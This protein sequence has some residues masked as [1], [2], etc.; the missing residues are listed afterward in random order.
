M[1][2]S[3]RVC[4]CVFSFPLLLAARVVSRV[5]GFLN[6]DHTSHLS[7]DERVFGHFCRVGRTKT[8]SKS[9]LLTLFSHPLPLS[10]VSCLIALS[11]I[12]CKA[13]TLVS[14]SLSPCLPVRR[15]THSLSSRRE[16]TNRDNPGAALPACDR[17]LARLF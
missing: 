16:Q 8:S 9:P 6:Q 4:V 13:K 11:D 14:L 15:L 12:M 17:G 5:C 10:R 3:A 7:D 1:C 2:V